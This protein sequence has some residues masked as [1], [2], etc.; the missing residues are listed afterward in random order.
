MASDPYRYFRIEAREL[1]DGLSQGVLELEKGSRDPE[2]IARLLRLAHTLKGAARVVKQPDIAAC[3]HQIEEIL[4]PL[5]ESGRGSDGPETR[6]L[7]ELVDRIDAG[8]QALSPQP[9]AA[10]PAAQTATTARAPTE[11]VFQSVR[12]DVED[13]DE[14]LR[15]ITETGVQLAAL[16]RELAELQRLGGLSVALASRLSLR[17]RSESR[18]KETTELGL[19]LD[20]QSGLERAVRALGDR[21]ERVEQELG[22]VH[23]GADRLRLIPVQ[24]LAAPLTRAVRD[25]AQTLGKEVGFELDGGALRLD[26]QVL[27]PLRDALL[28]LVRNAVAHGIEPAAER[29]AAGKSARGSVRLSVTRRAGEVVFSCE[30]DGGGIDTAAVRRELALRGA[31]DAQESQ[32]L[33]REALFERLLSG[34]VTTSREVTQISG[35]GIGLDVLREVTARLKGQ[36][37]LESEPGHGTRIVIRVPVSLASL[38]ALVV[39]S[40]GVTVAIPLDSVRE[41]VRLEPADVRHSARGDSV[42]REGK[43][44]PFLSLGRALRRGDSAPLRP[45]GQARAATSAVLVSADGR[46]AAFGVDLLR[47]TFD[48]VVKPLPH[49]LSTDPVVAGVSL[50]AEGIPRLVLDPAELVSAAAQDWP[51]VEAAPAVR[52]PI[53]VIDDS[54]TT[55]M[56]EQSILESAGYEVELAISAENGLEKARKKT[57]ALF[58]VDVEMP[59][60]SG[61]DFVTLTR[62]DPDLRQVPAIL[63]TSRNELEDFERGRKA[64]ASDYIVKGEFDQNRLLVSIERLL[65]R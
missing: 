51:S 47:G 2:V 24:T 32:T 43:V 46:D 53:L 34:G 56:L 38:R 41:T 57:Y 14:L 8:V 33:S 11:D 48:I 58:L 10:L 52:H 22:D 17:S 39:E 63:V 55:R 37:T 16:K 65:S 6:A 60:M 42:A 15:A 62:A 50:D 21:A 31:L 59:G 1:V 9:T 35:R 28:H 12:I 20:L 40:A 30:D 29:R 27:A 64:G 54:L 5:R 26:A 45:D 44:V 3:A 7:L 61:F 23:Q 19:A 36:V 25:A 18:P 13:M 4:A 49:G